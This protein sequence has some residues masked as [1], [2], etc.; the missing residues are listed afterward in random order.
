MDELLGALYK[1]FKNNGLMDNTTIMVINDNE[2]GAK[3]SLY[4][5]GIRMMNFIRFPPIYH[6]FVVGD[7]DVASTT[8]EIA[9]LSINWLENTVGYEFDGYSRLYPSDLTQD[10]LE[11]EHNN[12]DYR[13]DFASL[14]LLKAHVEDA[15]KDT[16]NQSN[17]YLRSTAPGPG[18]YP[19]QR[20]LDITNDII[21]LLDKRLKVLFRHTAENGTWVESDSGKPLL[22][23]SDGCVNTDIIDNN[24]LCYAIAYYPHDGLK[25]VIMNGYSNGHPHGYSNNYSNN[26]NCCLS[27]EVTATA[28]A[29]VTHNNE[30]KKEDYKGVMLSTP[31]PKPHPTRPAPEKERCII[32]F[33]WINSNSTNTNNMS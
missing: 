15:C 22:A 11:Q 30:R 19:T 25:V 17:H 8:F 1:W 32:L 4:E 10:G 29:A 16:E 27:A 5:Q 9:G 14:Q 13:N 6:N 12:S 3:E 31:Q 7:V 21:E 28:I 24:G 20:Y 23:T 33:R 18:A 2:Q 26:F